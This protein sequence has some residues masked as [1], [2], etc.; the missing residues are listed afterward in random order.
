MTFPKNCPNCK[1]QGW[2]DAW[3]KACTA[4]CVTKRKKCPLC[5]GTQFAEGEWE[6]CPDCKGHGAFDAFNKPCRIGTTLYKRDCRKCQG[7]GWGRVAHS[8]PNMQNLSGTWTELNHPTKVINVTQVNRTLQIVSPGEPWSPASSEIGTSNAMTF[9]GGLA[10]MTAQFDPITRRINFTTGLVWIAGDGGGASPYPA[11]PAPVPYPPAPTPTPAPG[12][13][14]NGNWADLRMAPNDVITIQRNGQNLTITCPTQPWS[15]A[16]GAI[17]AFNKIT[18]TTGLV[19]LFG[20]FDP[21]KREVT[22]TNGLCWH[23]HGA[24]PSPYPTPTPTPYPA[25]VPDQ[26]ARGEVACASGCGFLVTGVTPR[27]CCA[28]CDKRPHQHGPRCA[29]KRSAA[30]PVNNDINGNWADLRMAPNDVITIQRNGQNLTITCPTQPWSP[31]QGAIDT[32]NKITFTT[33]L[34]GLFGTFDPAKREVTFTNGLCWHPHGAPPAPPAPTPVP[35]P[36]PTPTPTPTPYPAPT[37]DI[38]GNWADLRMAPNDVITIQRNGQNLTI[39]CPTQPWSPAQGAIDAFNKITF[40]TGLV[41]LFGT[42]DPTKREVTFTNG[43]CWHP[44]GAPPA[45]TPTPTPVPY[46]TP[47]PTPTGPVAQI[48][49]AW[50][51]MGKPGDLTQVTQTGDRLQLVN[52]AESWSPA[53]G[54]IDAQNS[55]TFST[56]HVDLPGAKYDPVQKRISFCNGRVWCPKQVVATL[57][58]RWVE[59]GT[60]R[61]DEIT[62]TQTGDQLTLLCPAMPWERAE[63]RIASDRNVT[64]TGGLAGMTARHE[65]TE[66]KLYFMTGL[67]WKFVGNGTAP[68][69]PMESLAGQWTDPANNTVFIVTQNS[70]NLRIE[71]P[72]APGFPCTGVVEADAFTQR[73]IVKIPQL[74]MSGST[75]QRPGEKFIR[76]SNG[77]SWRQGQSYCSAPPSQEPSV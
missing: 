62:V 30:A 54:T 36:A 13:D 35:Y 77:L 60:G 43:L 3:G 34:V 14:I 59:D 48:G 67:K 70:N 33:G 19:G 12:G 2:F 16:Q 4:Q 1:G 37:N 45:P 8:D 10:G 25:P 21:A 50:H 31:A 57:A 66:G 51:D 26:S 42:F 73:P 56:Y 15:P 28:A 47:T 52:A 61:P 71:C 75:E 46:P 68:P 58:G 9:S 17:D 6:Q 41:G 18:F 23:P 22:F 20:T 40:T 53:N 24:P 65:P 76:W 39:T 69:V 55:I 38:N 29:Q 7:K 64:F 27:H 5:D 72:G 32:N 11:P 74:S 63:G 49:G 44:H